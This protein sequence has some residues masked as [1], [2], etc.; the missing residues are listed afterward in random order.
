[1]RDWRKAQ[2]GGKRSGVHRDMQA[3]GRGTPLKFP[4]LEKE[5]LA[6]CHLIDK[7]EGARTLTKVLLTLPQIQNLM[8]IG[9]R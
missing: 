1:M 5:L 6:S 3:I 7:K 4:D 8:V 9:A 2:A